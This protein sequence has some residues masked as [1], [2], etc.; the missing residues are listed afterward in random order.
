MGM[1]VWTGYHGRYCV[2]YCAV[3]LLFCHWIQSSMRWQITMRNRETI[4]TTQSSFD[5]GKKQI[6]KKKL[7]ENT[8]KIGKEKKITK[9]YK[10]KANH[11][12]CN[13]I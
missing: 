7:F 3:C 11:S 8:C 10:K 5:I 6:L 12:L 4:G 13:F 2:V 1:D 9:K